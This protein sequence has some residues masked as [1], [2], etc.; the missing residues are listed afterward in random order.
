MDIIVSR[1]R[2]AGVLPHYIYRALVPAEGIAVEGIRLVKEYLPDAYRDGSDL[3]ARAQM[4]AAAAMGATAFL[5]R[6][7]R[8]GSKAGAESP[9]ADRPRR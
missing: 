8:G 2:I 9:P 1:S 7:G 4:L 5:R 3:E 6:R